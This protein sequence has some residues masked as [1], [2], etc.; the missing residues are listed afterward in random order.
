MR[1]TLVVALLLTTACSE[2][3][4]GGGKKSA[5]AGDEPGPDLNDL[6]AECLLDEI[7]AEDVGI[8]DG[9]LPDGG[10]AA[11]FDPI[12]EWGAG[13]NRSS[14][15]TVAVADLNGD[16]IPEVVANFTGLIGGTGDLVVLNG[17][18]GNEIWSKP[19]E[20]GY[21][22]SPA[23]GDIDGDGQPEIFAVKQKSGGLLSLNG[24]FALAAWDAFGDKLWESDEFDNDNFD[25]ASAVSL[26]D[27]DHDGSP[28]I[29]VGRVIFNS[30]GTTRGVGEYGRGS[31]GVAP[32]I[33][34]S[35]ASVSAVADLDLDGVEEVI[36]GNAAYDPDGNTIWQTGG[37]DGMVGIANLDDDPEGEI[38]ASSFHTVRA[39]DTHGEPMWGPVEIPGANIVSPSAIADVDGDGYPEIFVAGGAN[40]VSLDRFGNINWSVPVHDTSGASGP[41]IFDFEGDGVPEVVYID[42]IQM[43]VVNGVTGEKKFH[44]T[45]H[46]SDTM[47]DYPVI[48]D[49]DAD[50]HAEIIVAH[51][52]NGRALSV[53]GDAANMWA[54]CRPLWNQHAYSINN[55]SDDLS[56]P[57]TQ[58]QGFTD[59]NTW[60]S[61]IDSLT[62][63]VDMGVRDLEAEILDVCDV[64]CESGVV[65]VVARVLNKSNIDAPAGIP[66]ALYSREYN[67]DRLL[68]VV[69]TVA[70]IPAG[71]TGESMVFEV[72]AEE[73]STVFRFVAAADDYG[74]GLGMILECSE[75]NN[76][77]AYDGEF[78]D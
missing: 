17:Q 72:D 25:Y 45:D 29:V 61:A 18:N 22:S 21:A 5:D 40:L 65:Y 13:E 28:E 36:T 24:T 55:V 43:L 11:G 46:A 75:D 66:V 59:H 3:N 53:Y 77:F 78:C 49:V 39:M 44:T 48:A 38:V 34:L 70:G 52:G 15:A 10:T 23:V 31:W 27:M 12:V 35:E 37:W 73:A 26:S 42:E 51:A 63:P 71:R 50:G 1:S 8:N 4:F 30:N 69:E 64:D 74:D 19:A 57:Q 16:G 6:P 56:V 7:A 2:Y 62:I 14:R 76:T 54:N 68:A 58:V 47:M 33:S 9:C 41:S 20:L 67:G 32:I 60:H